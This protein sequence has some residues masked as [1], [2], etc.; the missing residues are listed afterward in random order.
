MKYFTSRWWSVDSCEEGDDTFKRYRSYIASIRDQLSPD[1]LTL[2]EQ[3][4]LHDA[5]VRSFALS[6]P[7]ERAKLVL[8]G[9]DY[10]PVDRGEPP[11]MVR[12]TLRYRGVSG[13]LV[14]GRGGRAWFKHSD[15]VYNELEWLPGDV[16]EHRMLFSS[17]NEM[18][19]RFREFGIESV[20]VA[21]RRRGRRR[22]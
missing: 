4:S 16:F 10:S 17:G 2:V 19:V 22:R 5:R 6:G 12:F 3:V 20:P 14:H 15:L 1:L 13:F 11:A 18:I 7:R 21:T 8:A 9:Y